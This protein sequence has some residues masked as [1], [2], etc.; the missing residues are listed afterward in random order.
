MAGSIKSTLATEILDQL[1]VAVMVTDPEGTPVYLNKASSE[2]LTEEEAA[3]DKAL[4]AIGQRARR[5][6]K[7]LSATAP[8]ACALDGP[9]SLGD[10]EFEQPGGIRIPVEVHAGPLVDDDGQTTNAIAVF[11]NISERRLAERDRSLLAA[12]INS[13]SD[14]VVSVDL[15][16]RITSWNHGAEALY[17]YKAQEVLGRPSSILH[18]PDD[19]PA[20]LM[21][22]V[23]AGEPTL[24]TDTVRVRKD[25]SEVMVGLTVSPVHDPG[26]RVIGAASIARDISQRLEAERVLTEVRRELDLKNSRLER[27]NEELEQF[28]YVASHDLSEPLR[29]VAG[30]VG[31]LARRYQGRLDSDADEFIAF[32]VEGCERMRAMIE[33]L[34][35]YSRA[36]RTELGLETVDVTDIVSSVT[37]MLSIQIAESGG[38][39]EVGALPV[40]QG[41]KVQLIQVFQNL[42]AN[43]IKFRRTDVPPVVRISALQDAGGVWRFEVADNGIGIE[44]Q[45]RDRIF[46]MFQRLHSRDSYAGSGIGLAIAE[47]IVNRHGGQMGVE[48][49][50]AG[51]STFWFTL[52]YRMQA[53]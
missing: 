15:A 6:P 41:D 14:A 43:A 46:R 31:L 4:S 44:E 30:M 40:L 34:L 9:I 35:A 24:H 50:R 3:S 13:T 12:I 39:V 16:T 19:D 7:D 47:R 45:Y 8:A 38:V 33:D 10:V 22:R 29:A 49:N 52:P 21:S 51:G 48:A 11:W 37:A 27:S 20:H 5:P 26:G 25:G 32:A 53:A 42:V 18:P 28:A 36:G 17:G 2:F 1:P 23:V